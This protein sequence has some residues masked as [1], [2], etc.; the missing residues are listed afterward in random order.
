M[1]DL[2]K[3]IALYFRVSLSRAVPVI[4][5]AE[6][7]GVIMVLVMI[8]VLTEELSLTLWGIDKLSVMTVLHL[9]IP[10]F[11]LIG[12]MRSALFKFFYSPK[13]AKQ[14][15][16]KA[17]VISALI[18]SVLLDIILLILSPAYIR[19][20]VLVINSLNT[21]LMCFITASMNK[22]GLQAV[23]MVLMI[24]FFGQMALWHHVF[25]DGSGVSLSIAVAVALA[26]YTA[27]TVLNIFIMDQ[28][29]KRSGRKTAGKDGIR[30][31]ITAVNRL[32]HIFDN[33]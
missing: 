2:R 16:V 18:L 9:M 5:L 19:P 28:W 3:A 25:A 31:D 32:F 29:W 26:I 30:G 33:D 1:K 21:V 7:A 22:S 14:F 11:F 15:S 24:P 6:L 17:P 20:D 23:G 10:S 13:F 12:A 27:G 8:S 4:I